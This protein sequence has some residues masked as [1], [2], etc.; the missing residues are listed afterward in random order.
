M[1]R[2]SSCSPLYFSPASSLTYP[3]TL[4]NWNGELSHGQNKASDQVKLA[5]QKNERLLV[6]AVCGSGKTE[7]LFKGLEQAIYE[8]KTICIATPRTD[9]VLELLPRL[10]K[11]FPTIAISGLYG[12]SDDPLS[13]FIISTTHQL[14]RYKDCFDV[15][16]IDEVDAFPYEYDPSLQ[17]AVDKARKNNGALVYLTATP[18]RKILKQVKDNAL[19]YVRIPV[20]Y[21]GY[22]LPAPKFTWVG[23][24]RKHIRKGKLP[25]VLL[26][27]IEQQ[28]H[29][30]KPV[31]LFVPSIK[32]AER[33]HSLFEEVQV[34]CETVHSED[35]D[36]VEKVMRFRNRNYRL[37][38]TTTILERGVTIENVSIGVL[39]AEADIFTESSL[40]QIAGRAGRSEKYPEGEV[41]LFHYGKTNDMLLAFRHIKSMNVEADNRGWLKGKGV[42]GVKK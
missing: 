13:P 25:S 14:I 11:A 29:E 2:V 16:I 35:A 23:N 24:W 20:R 40:V 6:W 31:M 37:L 1:G 27:W 4:L 41:A 5:I 42:Y 9:V 39:G 8:N 18:S 26:K 7:V 3:P 34:D 30:K 33:I 10:R 28:F 19:P 21:H 12:G 32:L 36:R 22:P 15:M 38:L 17:Y